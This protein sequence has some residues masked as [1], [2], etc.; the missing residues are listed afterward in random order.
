[1]KIIII[2]AGGHSRAVY[3]CLRQNK[4]LEV[5]AFIDNVLGEKT[6]LIM[7]IPVLGPHSVIPGL[8]KEEN[9]KGFA[10][11]IGDNKVRA[12]RYNE[13]KL[14]GLE[15]INAIHPTAK[16]AYNVEIGN[17]VMIGINSTLNTHAK[18]GNNAI[19]NTGTI[20][21]H[22]DQIEENVHIAPGSS[23]AGRVTIKKNS[24][25][26]IGSVVKEYI[27]IGKNVIIGAGSVVL[28]DIPDNA[29]A[30]GSPAK[31]IKYNNEEN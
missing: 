19:I 11:G 14:L 6:E 7:N 12:E 2:G 28:E 1:M 26:G 8:I 18:I 16:I 21:E 24:F 30:V 15:P 9:V 10:L 29:I 23:I 20:V 31:I 22:E 4:N 17:G 13:L 5:V 25:I 27:T 3:E